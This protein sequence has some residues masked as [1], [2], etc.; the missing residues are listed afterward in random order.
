M[1]AYDGLPDSLDYRFLESYLQR[2]GLACVYMLD[3]SLIASECELGGK[4]NVYGIG[5]DVIA[6]TRNGHSTRLTDGVDC[7]VMWNDLTMSPCGDIWADAEKLGAIRTSLD[8]LIFWT[9]ISPL[10]R[11]NDEKTRLLV[12]QA[13]KNIQKGVPATIATKRILEDFGISDDVRI[14]NLT[15]PDFADKIQYTSKLYDDVLRWHFT[16]YGQAIHGNGKQAQETTDEVNSTVSQSLVMPLS[17][18][19]ARK[20]SIDKINA[21]F[22]TSINV[23]LSGAW[24]AEVTKYEEETGEESIDDSADDDGAEK[25]RE[26]GGED[27]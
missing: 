16:K 6:T 3:G 8:F 25:E 7:V 24:K 9:R 1:F 19:R 27:A 17:M 14:D 21:L 20:E 11:V 22:G 4:L 13:F 18:L 5:E 12:V 10:I 15:Q 2:E 26:E 23:E